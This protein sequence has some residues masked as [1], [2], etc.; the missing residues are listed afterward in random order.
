VRAPSGL[1]ADGWATALFASG[2]RALPIAEKEGLEVLL[3]DRDGEVT[4]VGD[5]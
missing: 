3:V 1:A 5:L 4:A 2:A